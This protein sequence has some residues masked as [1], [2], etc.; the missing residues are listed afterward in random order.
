MIY[1]PAILINRAE[2]NWIDRRSVALTINDLITEFSGFS[3]FVS[4]VSLDSSHILQTKITKTGCYCSFNLMTEKILLLICP[5]LFLNL[6]L[7][8]KTINKKLIS[9]RCRFA[10]RLMFTLLLSWLFGCEGSTV[11]NTSSFVSS[12][13]YFGG[14]GR[15]FGS[16]SSSSDSFKS[17]F[18]LPPIL[19]APSHVLPQ[20][21]ERSTSADLPHLGHLMS[22][23]QTEEAHEMC[24][25]LRG[26]WDRAVKSLNVST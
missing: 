24:W 20:Q 23:E 8:C 3:F 4:D 6:I 19:S 18:H 13:F 5:F 17:T 12:D 7:F 16:F 22:T 11:K 2:K 21:T 1:R 9:S 25:K 10:A 26:S 15:T 14:F